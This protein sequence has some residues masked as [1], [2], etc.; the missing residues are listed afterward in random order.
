HGMIRPGEVQYM[1]AGAGVE[2]SEFNPSSSK[3]VHLMQIWIRPDLKNMPP[4]YEQRK[5]PSIS[6]AGHLT[7]LASQDGR[8]GSIR[9]NQDASV[10]AATFLAGQST[11]HALSSARGA[12][13][14]IL[15]GSLEVD[16]QT[17]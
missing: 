15:R 5:F 8:D 4:R 1:S 17:L 2:H 9:I 11:H 12:W 16:E 3:P 10:C 6:N 14:Q 13:V 7:L